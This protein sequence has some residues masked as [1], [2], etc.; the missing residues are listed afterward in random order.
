[1][2]R[3]SVGTCHCPSPRPPKAAPLQA[4]ASCVSLPGRSVGCASALFSSTERAGRAQW[5]VSPYQSPTEERRVLK[6]RSPPFSPLPH[7][8]PWGH[9][10]NKR[11]APRSLSQRQLR[12]GSWEWAGSSSGEV[13]AHTHWPSSGVSG[14]QRARG[15]W[16]PC[17]P[18]GGL[19]EGEQ[20]CSDGRVHRGDLVKTQTPSDSAGLGR[21]VTLSVAT[22]SHAVWLLLWPIPGPRFE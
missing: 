2:G 20:C 13:S 5:S 19:G 9:L 7:T 21:A 15:R 3:S 17:F 14:R 18:C 10:P 1:M 8:G 6:D 11:L 22:G 12:Y 16:S 4:K